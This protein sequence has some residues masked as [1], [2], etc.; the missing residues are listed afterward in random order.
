MPQTYLDSYDEPV[1]IDFKSQI[2]PNCTVTEIYGEQAKE[3]E[4]LRHFRDN[5][6]RKTPEGQELIQ[7]YYQWS[8]ML[9]KAMNEDAL[10]KAEIKAV[11]DDILPL[12]R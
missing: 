7:L 4:R 12:I 11:I 6:L 10:F 5:V 1:V 3:T 8:P 9:V 2:L